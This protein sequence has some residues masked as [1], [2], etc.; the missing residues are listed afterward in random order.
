MSNYSV[1]MMC[2]AAVA[3][4]AWFNG[5]WQGTHG[6]D[7]VEE[8]WSDV[9]GGTMMSMFRWLKE[10]KVRFYELMTLEPEAEGVLLRIKHFSPGLMGWEEKNDSVVLAL[11]HLSPGK[12]V[13]SRRGHDEPLWLVYEQNQAD[14]LIVHFDKGEGPPP[15]EAMFLYNRL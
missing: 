11:V 12:A 13:F 15:P 3:D 9:A 14:E 10:G 6:E 8:Q 4:L 2:Q 5:R 1:D 7:A